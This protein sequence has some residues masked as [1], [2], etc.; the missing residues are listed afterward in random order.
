MNISRSTAIQNVYCTLNTIAT[1]SS[2]SGTPSLA[3]DLSDPAV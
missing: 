1:L 2:W 3:Y